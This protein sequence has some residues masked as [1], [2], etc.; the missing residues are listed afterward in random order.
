MTDRTA[1][2]R[3]GPTIG[4]DYSCLGVALRLPW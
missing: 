1:D 4:G 3:S 2:A